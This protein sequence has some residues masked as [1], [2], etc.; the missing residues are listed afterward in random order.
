[1]ESKLKVT[2]WDVLVKPAYL[3]DSLQQTNSPDKVY[4]MIKQEKKVIGVLNV[5]SMLL[6]SFACW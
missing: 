3:L 4:A 5:R 6:A 2:R 1:M